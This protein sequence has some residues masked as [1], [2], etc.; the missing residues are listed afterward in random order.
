MSEFSAYYNPKTVSQ[1]AAVGL[2]VRRGM[3]GSI[4]GLHRSPLHGVSPEFADYRSYTPGDDLRSLDWR[5]YARSNRF[6]VKRY[7]EESNLDAYVVLDASSSMSYRRQHVS[8]FEFAATLAVSLVATLVRQR[9]AAGLVTFNKQGESHVRMSSSESQLQRICTVLD[10]V[11]PNGET[12]LGGVL[13]NLADQIKRRGLIILISDFLTDL[14]KLWPAVRKLQFAGHEIIAF[15]IL[16][17]DEIELPFRGPVLFNDIEKNGEQLYAEPQGFRAA[18]K[19]AMDQFIAT[20]RE[21][22]HQ[23]GI[24]FLSLF[25][26]EN[27]GSRVSHFLKRRM[28]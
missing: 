16:D 27:M 25:T 20:L 24:D 19:R 28:G 17:R 4:S 22:F 3:E 7:E 18:Y 26:D 12:E 13:T 11:E 2:R 23:L 9:D 10:T 8:K 1:I 21:N 6:Y 5:V 15:Q 14:D